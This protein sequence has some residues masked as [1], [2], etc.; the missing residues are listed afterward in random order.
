VACLLCLTLLLLLLLLLLNIGTVYVSGMLV[1]VLG[2]SAMQPRWS[3][4]CASNRR[5][6]LLL[7]LLLAAALHTSHTP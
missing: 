3:R 7:L 5:L 4:M 2:D 6:L 1:V